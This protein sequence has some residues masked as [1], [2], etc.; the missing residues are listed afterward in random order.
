[1]GIKMMSLINKILGFF[2]LIEENQQIYLVKS[3]EKSEQGNTSICM[4]TL[5]NNNDHKFN[6]LDILNNITLKKQINS[7]DL[8]LIETIAMTEGDIIIESKSYE[9]NEIYYLR[10]VVSGE[11][12]Q[13][14]KKQLEQNKMLLHR[15]NQQYFKHHLSI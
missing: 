4:G 8:K 13:I 7:Y 15:L 10:S 9:N 1:M 2:K 6:C 3:L 12:W 5:S 11:T 14:T